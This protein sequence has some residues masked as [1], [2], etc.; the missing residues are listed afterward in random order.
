MSFFQ[1]IRILL[2]AITLTTTS[3]SLADQEFSNNIEISDARLESHL[4]YLSSKLVGKVGVA[5]Q[6][7]GKNKI[8]SLHGDDFFPMASTYKIAIAVSLL[9]DVDLQKLTLQQSVKVNPADYIAGSGILTTYFQHQG[10]EISLGNLIDLMIIES[11]NSAT[12]LCLSLA[13]GPSQVS[14][15]L[16]TLGI[17]N[18]SVDRAADELLQDFYGLEAPA[19]VNNV[20]KTM[21]DDP[22]L[23]TRLNAPNL[24]FEADLRDQTTPLAMLSLLTQIHEANILS[25]ASQ[26]FLLQA[27]ARTQTAQNRIKGKLPRNTSVAHKS[28]GLGGIANDV[29]YI[30]LPNEQLLAIAIFTK[31]SHTDQKDRDEAI[32]EITRTLYDVFVLSK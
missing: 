2:V 12:Q 1:L 5:A 27:M 14:Q 4:L 25:P 29:G 7:V 8:I 18:Q 31:S 26:R 3:K 30:T 32:A 11:D 15:T 9:R 17:T 16:K 21:K 10:L 28:G 20:N 24:S 13:G 22:T 19:T 23:V 6:I